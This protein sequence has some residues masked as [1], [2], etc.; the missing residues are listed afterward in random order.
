MDIVFLQEAYDNKQDLVTLNTLHKNFH[1]KGE[2]TVN[3]TDCVRGGHIP[4]GI[5]VDDTDCF[6]RGHIPGGTTVD[7]T[8]CFCRG[9]IPGGTTVDD[10][11]CFRR[12]HIPGGATVDNTDCVRRGHIPGGTTVDDT[13]CFRR[14]HIPGGATVNDTDCV[15]RGHI[16]GGATV[17]D[18]DCFRRGH[19]PCGA[20]VGDT[21]CF[22]IGHIPG[23]V[24]IVWKSSLDN[25]VTPL[26]F[27]TDW[28][29]S[30]RMQF[31]NQV[32]VITCVCMSY[33]CSEN[34][35]IYLENLNII[36]NIIDDLKCIS[37]S[38][39]GDWNSNISDS[40]SLFGNHVNSFCT[41]NNLLSSS[42]I[43]LP[44]DTF[45]HYGEA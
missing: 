11:D 27:N 34:E 22:R 32:Y 8:Y 12:G 4:G 10:T 37:I 1:G 39:V 44:R 33:G 36:K 35:D 21:D 2:A 15:R 29:T 38:L 5:T 25:N 7:D 18:T 9:H 16:P 6:R 14:G 23:G 24:V 19:I 28:H 43:Y 45:T 17:D 30:I 3:D 20:T 40:T 42:E 31:G 13:D 41:E 26:N